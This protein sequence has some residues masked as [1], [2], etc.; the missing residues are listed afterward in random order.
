MCPK[1]CSSVLFL[2]PTE[3][4]QGRQGSVASCSGLTAPRPH[5]EWAESLGGVHSPFL[6][7]S[8]PPPPLELDRANMEQ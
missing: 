5:Q 7:L 6:L 2:G 4:C 3:L 8:S 1:T